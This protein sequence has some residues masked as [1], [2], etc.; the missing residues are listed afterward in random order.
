MGQIIAGT[1]ATRAEAAKSL[2]ERRVTDLDTPALLVDL[3]VMEQNLQTM[4]SFFRDKRARLRPHFKNHRV[5][6]L[7]ARQ[8][9]YRAIGITCARLWQAEVL[10]D[11]GFRHI[12]IANELAGE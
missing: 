9:E 11:A 12:L 4:A 6:E 8:M 7:A 2:V 1:P 5:I 10:V 3:R